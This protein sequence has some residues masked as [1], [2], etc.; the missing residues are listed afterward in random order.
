VSTAKTLR[1]SALEYLTQAMF[2][3]PASAFTRC[4]SGFTMPLK[5][6]QGLPIFPGPSLFLSALHYSRRPTAPPPL[7]PSPP[8][9]LPAHSRLA[10]GLTLA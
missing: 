9:P 3:W 1:C 5:L 6:S 10:A 4:V 8:P 7:P 2:Q